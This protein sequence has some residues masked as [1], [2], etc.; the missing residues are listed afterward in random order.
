[1]CVCVDLEGVVCLL[2]LLTSCLYQLKRRRAAGWLAC[3]LW[4]LCVGAVEGSS[5]SVAA[6]VT[7][8]VCVLCVPVSVSGTH[9]QLCYQ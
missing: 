6:C 1:M 8:C 2:A 4:V 5:L 9:V 7:S 3:G